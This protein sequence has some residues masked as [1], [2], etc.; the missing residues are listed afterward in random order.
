MRNN[1]APAAGSPPWE[2]ETP[3][4]Q[5]RVIDSDRRTFT[6]WPAAER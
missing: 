2:R 4:A 6:R 3:R 5:L 1:P